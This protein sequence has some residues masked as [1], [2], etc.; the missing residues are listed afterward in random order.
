MIDSLVS[1]ALS[2]RVIALIPQD[3]EKKE[4]I[5]KTL[6]A[7]YALATSPESIIDPDALV[8]SYVEC[9]GM[10]GFASVLDS[11]R[12]DTHSKTEDQT[13]TQFLVRLSSRE[14]GKQIKNKPKKTAD[15]VS[16]FLTEYERAIKPPDSDL[17]SA[18]TIA[19]TLRMMP[20]LDF[21]SL[22][23]FF[24]QPGDVSTQALSEFIRSLNL[25][26]MDPEEALRACLQSFRLPGEA[27]QIDRIVK[28]IAYEYY[29]AHADLSVVGNYFA[30]AD[31]AYTF[32]FSVIM[33]NTDQQP[34]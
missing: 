11:L 22:G 32:L 21:D 17:G 31:A 2:N 27:Q 4:K 14:C 28:E 18:K 30:S 13:P 6:N 7:F 16:Q 3:E 8:P 5:P 12:A 10:R 26:S 29:R 25:K 24:G 15:I 19:W 23:E 9:L 1:V 20:S 33:L 34:G